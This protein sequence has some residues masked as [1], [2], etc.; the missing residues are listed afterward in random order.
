VRDR[1]LADGDVEHL[2]VVFLQPRRAHDRA[3]V[4]DVG[5]DLLDL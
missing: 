5:H 4:V 2:Q 1:P 3:L